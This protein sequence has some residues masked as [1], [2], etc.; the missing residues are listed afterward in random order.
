MQALLSDGACM[1]IMSRIMSSSSRPIRPSS[2]FIIGTAVN[3]QDG[4]MK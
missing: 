1:R 2:W 3:L 4:G